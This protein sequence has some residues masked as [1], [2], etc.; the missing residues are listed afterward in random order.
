MVDFAYGVSLSSQLVS[1]PSLC[2][3]RK[4]SNAGKDWRQEEKGTREDQM[5]GW[6][7]WLNEHEF[8]QAPGDGEGQGSLACCSTWG[9]KE[10]ET[11]DQLN[12][13]TNTILII[14]NC[15]WDHG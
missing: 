11:T 14:Y 8:E 4:G 13:N 5:V 2:R 1:V 6:H 7:H 9:G 10:S 15:Y 12:K 3:I